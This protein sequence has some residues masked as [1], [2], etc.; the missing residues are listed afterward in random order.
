MHL[1][2]ILTGRLVDIVDEGFDV[3]VRATS[4]MPDSDWVARKRARWMA[5]QTQT[6]RLA[7]AVERFAQ[8]N[9]VLRCSQDPQWAL[10]AWV[11]RGVK[12]VCA[13]FGQRRGVGQVLLY[14]SAL[15]G[16]RR[17]FSY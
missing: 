3:A 6:K 9:R 13:Y 2:I 4:S 7:G 5:N 17:V 14:R 10:A 15:L 8:A 11:E 12:V 1:D 16:T